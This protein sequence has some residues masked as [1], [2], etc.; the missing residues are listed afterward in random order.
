MGI[1]EGFSVICGN[2]QLYLMNL[3]YKKEFCLS[4]SIK[5]KK[6]CQILLV[7]DFIK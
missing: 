5:I 2:K 7:L 1:L 3:P 6:K 4:I